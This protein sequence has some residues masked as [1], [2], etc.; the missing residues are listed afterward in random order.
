MD[1]V[2]QTFGREYTDER[3][4]T[5]AVKVF[6]VHFDAAT[7]DLTDALDI[8]G[9]PLLDNKFSETS[10]YLRCVSREVSELE[11]SLREYQVTCHYAMSEIGQWSVRLSTQTL[12]TV[13]ETTAWKFV[14]GH[15]PA[16]FTASPA[17]YLHSL[18]DGLAGESVVNRAGDPFDP[19]PMTQRKQTVIDASVLVDDITDLGVGITSVGKLMS[20]IGKV[21]LEDLRVFGIPAPLTYCEP[22]TLLMD[23]I[24]CEKVPLTDGTCDYRVSFRMV[25]DP[26]GHCQVV[27]NAGYSEL[28]NDKARKV[29][30]DDQVEVSS[31]VPL[32]DDGKKVEKAALPA[33][34]TYIVF[35]DRDTAYFLD[36]NFPGDFCELAPTEAP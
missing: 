31:P 36:F 25:Y 12:D 15:P 6:H 24:A 8:V 35:P 7:G 30:G 1:R 9:V 4:Q 13:L 34:V 18:P 17:R 19:P 26:M 21:N 33:G 22:W 20:Y 29:T 23:D 2:D 16:R 14:G 10:A 11:R 32:D 28:I 3:G 27:L 5:R